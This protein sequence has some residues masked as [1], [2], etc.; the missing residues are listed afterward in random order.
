MSH[1]SA[2]TSIAP[3]TV[4][5][6]DNPAAPTMGRCQKRV[7]GEGGEGTSTT[8]SASSRGEKSTRGKGA[9]TVNFSTAPYTRKKTS[10]NLATRIRVGGRLRSTVSQTANP[11]SQG[12]VL[13]DLTRNPTGPPKVSG[14]GSACSW[15][16][17]RTVG[18][19]TFRV[20]PPDFDIR[21]A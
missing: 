20:S 6:A 11:N 10:I 9:S 19:I 15:G 1:S 3:S 14:N 5:S 4:P 18:G 21:K 2:P 12:K 13:V 8:S 7:R 17:L 16:P